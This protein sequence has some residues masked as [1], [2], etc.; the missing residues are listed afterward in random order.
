MKRTLYLMV[1]LLGL[2]RTTAA[3]TIPKELWGTWVVRREVPTT[4]ISC[5]GEQ[6]DKTLLRTRVEYSA[7]FFRWDE[8]ITENP[9]AELTTIAAE[10]FHDENSGGSPN[11]SQVTFQRLGIKADKVTQVVIQ[12]PA[13]DITGATIE[14]PG[15]NVLIKDK[16]TIIFSVCNVYFEAER[17]ADVKSLTAQR[18][19]VDQA[20]PAQ[21]LFADPE[22]KHLWQ[23][24]RSAKDA[25][26]VQL[27][28]GQFARFW[29]GP[30]GKALIRLEEPHEDSYAYTD[31]C[32]SKTGHLLSLRFEVRSV[33]GWGLREERNIVNGTL[34][35]RTLEFFNTEDERPVTKPEDADDVR[36]AVRPP[37]Y[38]RKSQ[39]P[40][41]KLLSQ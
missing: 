21:R 30:N 17:I 13:A 9:R 29:A 32:F 33:Q 14:I 4:T 3:Q 16:D 35:P 7:G 37:V 20:Q 31:S 34:R 19:G 8:V 15:D 22:G 18:C 2:L 38:A 5:W 40:F 39:W 24:Y 36:D 1:M 28:F 23:E 25:P 6:V 10:K 11:G 41:A 12:H 27:G 26:E